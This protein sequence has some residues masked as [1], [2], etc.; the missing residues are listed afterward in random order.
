MSDFERIN[1][2]AIAAAA[3]DEVMQDSSFADKCSANEPPGTCDGGSTF[4]CSGQY[5]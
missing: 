1:I 4:V 3:V 5:D 2:E